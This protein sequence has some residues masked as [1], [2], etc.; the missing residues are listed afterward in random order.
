MAS[1]ADV[2]LTF[3]AEFSAV[4][5]GTNGT[6]GTVNNSNGNA[7]A[8]PPGGGQH[9]PFAAIAAKPTLLKHGH[10]RF[11]IMDAPKQHNLH[12][13]IKECKRQNVQDV[14]RVC[15]PTYTASDLN[16]AGIA[17]HEMA[18]DDGTSPPNDVI[19][20]WLDLV[21]KKFGSSPG[22]K[23]D[24]TN[25][26]SSTAAPGGCIAVHCVA[27]LGRAPVLVAL[28]LIEY[29]GCDPIYAVNFIRKH[30]RGAINEKQLRYLE[31]YKKR[32]KPKT[33][34]CAIS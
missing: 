7:A 3:P 27:G 20:L 23:K 13:Y 4:V 1:Q 12:L 28:A 33:C 9:R 34:G 29:G 14:V 6:T 11:M 8:P 19:N 31:Q 10:M 22:K 2:K 17:L 24:D 25:S 26:S 21:Q 16:A 18:Y 5:K 30:R 32:Q 15:A